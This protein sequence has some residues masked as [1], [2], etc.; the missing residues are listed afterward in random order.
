MT[1]RL[2]AREILK[3]ADVLRIKVPRAGVTKEKLINRLVANNVLDKYH[4]ITDLEHKYNVL[5]T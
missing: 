5:Q 4:P 2:K 1:T 3:V